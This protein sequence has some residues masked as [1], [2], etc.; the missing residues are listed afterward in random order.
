MPYSR[1]YAGKSL[2]AYVGD[3]LEKRTTLA[4]RTIDTFSGALVSLRRV[5]LKEI[6]RSRA[7]RTIGGFYCFEETFDENK[8]ETT[9]GNFTLILEPEESD[10]D[11]FFLEPRNGEAW[12]F[13]FSRN[14]I[15]PMP[16]PKNPLEEIRLA[17]S[18]SYPF[19]QN[20]TLA[21][22]VVVRGGG[23]KPPTL[24][25]AVVQSEYFSADP[26]DPSLKKKRTIKT[27]SDK[28]GE[29]VLFFLALPD[30][31]QII[32]VTAISDGQ[33]IPDPVKVKITEGA[34]VSKVVL[35]FPQ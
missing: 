23:N 31:T 13:E 6:P 21:R 33:Q 10:A 9:T 34:T 14:V 4:V 20:T 17:P 28:K 16:D 22:G 32:D 1:P 29:F 15:L 30:A 27:Q 2:V 24:P 8:D 26:V 25:G 19:P 18:P 35:A 3:S 7:F 12:T 5:T 11:C